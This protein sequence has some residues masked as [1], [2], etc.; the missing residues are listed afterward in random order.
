M[1]PHYSGFFVPIEKNYYFGVDLIYY[2]GNIYPNTTNTVHLSRCYDLKRI[3]AAEPV[4]VRQINN[5]DAEE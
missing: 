3:E 4:G 2:F 5:L 1:K